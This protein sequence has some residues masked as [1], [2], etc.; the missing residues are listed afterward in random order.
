VQVAPKLKNK[1][2]EEF[3]G[4]HTHTLSLSYK[5]KTSV[6]PKFKLGRPESHTLEII[7]T[8]VERG[9]YGERSGKVLISSVED[10]S[11]RR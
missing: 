8:R 6:E 7:M 3:F 9:K 1:K 4:K 10:L 11:A 5:R 2:L